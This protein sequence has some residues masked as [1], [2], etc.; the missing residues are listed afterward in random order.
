MP[1]CIPLKTVVLN[2]GY[3]FLEAL[4]DALDIE[5][6]ADSCIKRERFRGGYPLAKILKFLVL[7]R[8]LVPDSK[9]A[10]FQMKN[11]FYGFDTDFDLQNVYRTLDFISALGP[12]LQKHL[13]GKVRS[14]IG[15]DLSDALYDVT[16]YFFE[17][18]FPDG[19]GLLRKRGVS[20]EHRTTPSCKWGCSWT[21]TASP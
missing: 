18:D 10:S 20:K 16:N 21:A 19:D 15:R 2:Y 13:D 11:G 4:Y 8:V 5:S 9:R 12:E 1:E 17:I 7:S 14:R 3:K 6:F